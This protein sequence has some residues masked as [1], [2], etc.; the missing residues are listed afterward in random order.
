MHVDW[1]IHV[2]KSS[3]FR[4]ILIYFMGYNINYN[5]MTD[6]NVITHLV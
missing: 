4:E 3:L 6:N 1:L 5:D 2:I